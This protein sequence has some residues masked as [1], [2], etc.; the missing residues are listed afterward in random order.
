MATITIIGTGLIGCSFG[1]AL[2]EHG[3]FIIGW[4]KNMSNLEQAKKIGALDATSQPC[5]PSGRSFI[6]AIKQS[7][8]VII[9]TPVDIILDI[10]PQVLD[11]LTKD[12]VVIDTGSTK[13]AICQR[14]QNHPRRNAFIASHPMAGSE[15]SGPSAAR[16]NLFEGKTV[17]ICES[18]LTSEKSMRMAMEIF[19]QV[20]LKSIFLTPRQHDSNAA[21]VSHIPQI[22]AYA[23]AGLPEFSNS[24]CQSWG[25]MASSGF[26]SSTRLASSIPEVWLPILSQNKE[27][28]V[29]AL[30]S[31]GQTI[32]LLA[33]SLSDSN[34]IPLRTQ[35]DRA[36][37]TRT[38][39]ESKQRITSEK[40]EILSLIK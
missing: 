18:E 33:D 24:A 13:M 16:A 38:T 35:M 29:D 3:H 39:F 30:R 32:D 12:A 19:S 7:T 22:L 20:G 31:L 28:V 25:D 15:Q 9:A 26:D 5:L 1:L 40:I 37:K 2:K 10:L 21:L 34:T 6:Q 23:Y 27:F 17:A 4:D 14:V 8:I 11:N 36:R